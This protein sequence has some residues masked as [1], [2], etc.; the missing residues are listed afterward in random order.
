VE[1]YNLSQ[2][3]DLSISCYSEQAF[4]E[5]T[6]A[7]NDTDDGGI[8]WGW[9]PTTIFEYLIPKK[10]GLDT[11]LFAQNPLTI[12]KETQKQYLAG[13][14]RQ[15]VHRTFWQHNKDIGQQVHSKLNNTEQF[16]RSCALTFDNDIAKE[17]IENMMRF[18]ASD[19]RKN[20]GTKSPKTTKK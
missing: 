13:D 4:K 2:Q 10:S 7:A 16:L 17:R 11:R 1:A 8:L 6:K 19:I 3:F 14:I 20:G 9:I 15:L 12:L 18:M 5:L